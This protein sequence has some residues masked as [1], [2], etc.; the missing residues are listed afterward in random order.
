MPRLSKISLYAL[1]GA[2]G[3]SAVWMFILMLSNTLDSGLLTELLLGALSGMFIGGF[4]WS[5]EAITGRQF[6]TAIRRAGYGAASG[7]L[8]GAAGAA[9]G[10]T[11]FTGLGRIVADQGGFSASLGISLSVAFGWAIL[12]AAVGAS[13]G[14][15]IRSRERIIYGLAGGSLGGFLGGLLFNAISAT[16]IWSALAGLFFLGGCIGGFI[17][18]VEEAFVSAKVKVIKGRHINREFS[19]LKEINSIG[20]DDRSDVCLSGA[21]GVAMQH[22]II[23]RKK[24]AFSIEQG[25]AGTGVYVNHQKTEKCRLS[26]G[27]VIRVGSILLMFN[28]LKKTAA[29][30]LFFL[31]LGS[32]TP[33]VNAALADE[34]HDVRITQFDLNGFP[35][36]TAYVSIL[37][38]NGKAVGGLSAHDVSLMENGRPVAI[39]E[40]RMGGT[41]G[42]REPL[43]LVLDKSGSMTGDKI[44]RAKESVLRFLSLMEPGDRASLFSFSDE[45]A[46]IESLTGNVEKLKKATLAIQPGGH[47]ALY[48]AIV[49]GVD[50]VKGYSG[51]RAV[52]VLSDGIANRGVMNIEQSIDCAVKGYVSVY[53]IGLGEDVR[54]A[55]L[56][57]IAQETGG[58][59]FFTPSPEGLAAIYEA[60]SR[61]IKNEYV[62]TFE[63]GKRGEYLRNVSLELKKGTRAGRAY[64]QPKSSLFGTGGKVPGWALVVPLM[65]IAGLVGISLRSMER[66]YRTGHLSVVK[67]R[68]S[69][70]EIDINSSISL[71]RDE[72]NALGLFQ[73]NRIDQYHAEVQKEN[74]RYFIKDKGTS[75]GTFVNR[76]KIFSVRTLSDGDV[77]DIGSARILFSQ[78]SGHT[79]PACGSA[80]RSKAKFCPKCGVRTT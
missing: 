65:S 42:K 2:L 16:N 46:E 18:L 68:S 58:T 35:L 15:M 12:G 53:V 77:I 76:E 13:G 69:R 5:H 27:D 24:G 8:G 44:A 49:K 30:V 50:S 14:L 59:Y 56:E 74:G 4:L 32:T 45:V 34:A 29:C 63:T 9:L 22:A 36:V 48:D 71:G 31:A 64:F 54:T 10:N 20:R 66:R 19:I 1:A 21:E 75:S 61:R 79:C 80:V 23:T 67:G 3:G 73:D 11:V 57:R 7:I 60:I 37:D 40:M 38:G 17:S 51:R 26:D 33:T 62:I 28:A 25:Q 6:R 47:T 52:I 39:K 55:R 43:S 41:S 72:R 70:K 78:G